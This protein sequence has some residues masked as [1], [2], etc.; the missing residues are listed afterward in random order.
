MFSRCQREAQSLTLSVC[1]E[2]QTDNDLWL[3]SNVPLVSTWPWTVSV[4]NLV[5]TV[6]SS[7]W[8]LVCLCPSH[9]LHHNVL[10][11][12]RMTTPG[13]FHGNC[14]SSCLC[15]WVDAAMQKEGRETPTYEAP[16]VT[17]RRRRRRHEEERCLWH[18][19]WILPTFCSRHTEIFTK[20]NPLTLDLSRALT[21][22]CRRRWWRWWCV[23]E[24]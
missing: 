24:I 23:C 4:L 22:S 1:P 15:H 14:F 21:H 2:H 16:L 20:I 9:A 5:F 3:L 17:W 18:D 12:Q 6:S 11:C 19:N 13:H 8:T 10:S 7:S